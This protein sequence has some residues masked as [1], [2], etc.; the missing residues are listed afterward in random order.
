[1]FRLRRLILKLAVAPAAIALGILVLLV[2]IGFALANS[3]HQIGSRYV[4]HYIA[5]YHVLKIYRDKYLWVSVGFPNVAAFM[6]PYA[7]F[8]F[9]VASVEGFIRFLERRK[10]SRGGFEVIMPPAGG[11]GEHD[12]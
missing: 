5:E 10:R 8:C 2:A 1:M 12:H 11:E 6:G 9:A 4:V 7:M 3:G